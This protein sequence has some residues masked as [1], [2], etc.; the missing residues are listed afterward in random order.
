MQ[1]IQVVLDEE[2]LRAADRAASRAKMNRSAWVR[3]ALRKHL[4]EERRRER[5]RRDEKGYLAHPDSIDEIELWEREAVWP[6]G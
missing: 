2:L 4:A 5:E 6:Q 1:T 3:L